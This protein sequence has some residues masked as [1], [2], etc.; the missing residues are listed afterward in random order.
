MEIQN[1]KKQDLRTLKL[2]NTDHKKYIDDYI[3]TAIDNSEYAK[4]VENMQDIW[5]TNAMYYEGYQMYQLPGAY[6]SSNSQSNLASNGVTDDTMRAAYEMLKARGFVDTTKFNTKKDENGNY[7][8]TNNKIK[9]V[10][11][12]M[13]AY[14]TSSRKEITVKSDDYPGNDGIE[15]ALKQKLHQLATEKRLWQQLWNPCI[16]LVQVYGLA[17]F[18]INFNRRINPPNGDFEFHYYHPSD[19]LMDVFSRQKY[20]INSN[21]II[22]KRQM[23]LE[24]AREYFSGKQFKLSQDQIN[25]ITG[26]SEF[27]RFNIN[28][29]ELNYKTRID[30]KDYVTI[31]YGEIS[32]VYSNK[33]KTA[34]ILGIDEM[35]EGMNIKSDD[36]FEFDEKWQ[37][38]FI[39][40]PSLGTV[41]FA[42]AQH[43]DKT[44]MQS[45]QYKC[46]PMVNRESLIRQH[47]VSEVEGLIKLQDIINIA[48]SL[49]FQNA[50]EQN[51]VRYMLSS[52]LKKY[53]KTFY[54]FLKG[55]GIFWLDDAAL[56][57]GTKMSD[58]L[59]PIKTQPISPEII[60]L[61]NLA[62]DAI[63]ENGVVHESLAGEYPDKGSISGV[64]VQKLKESNMRRLNYKEENINWATSVAGQKL[65]IIYAQE[66]KMDDFIRTSDRNKNEPIHTVLNGTM[67]L[68]QYIQ[69]L[70]ENYPEMEVEQA[71]EEF[72]KLNDVEIQYS[73]TDQRGGMQDPEEIMNNK[74]VVYINQL[75]DPTTQKPYRMKIKVEMD[76]ESERNELE[77]VIKAEAMRGRG[78]LSR[79][80]YYYFMGGQFR[81]KSDELIGNLEK[82][83]KV[84]QMADMLS[85]NPE[86]M[87]LVQAVIAKTQQQGQDTAGNVQQG[88]GIPSAR[89][90]EQAVK[91]VRQME[92]E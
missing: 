58:L 56:Q 74:S 24:E 88:Q 10:I 62:V 52:A 70:Q 27:N 35:L 83:N 5:T 78:D 17:W 71:A 55:S 53:E 30:N 14:M 68:Q 60:Q 66:Y 20:Y 73:K 7:W 8:L 77:T 69:F 84:L 75:L 63:K 81:D 82:E 48:N 40:T 91:Q 51:Y 86:I 76:F 23:E 9:N 11:D 21:Y 37:F 42:E 49:I 25:L 28:N 22:R 85:K 80:D 47:P 72:E 15:F 92:Q 59:H 87:Q 3:Q 16:D 45:Y 50:A 19:V 4:K 26:D 43:Y 13:K 32:K 2:K 12:G 64:A 31:Y 46:I 33:V 89:Q 90:R 34:N 18:D 36:N 54:K 79:K 61:M 41:Y 57:P 29:L 65:Y 38:D 6:T 39:F 1:I 44:D 67:T